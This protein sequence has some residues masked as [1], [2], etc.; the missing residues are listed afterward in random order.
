MKTAREILTQ[1]NTRSTLNTEQVLDAMEKYAQQFKYDY[2]QN[3]KCESTT[4]STW[5]CNQCGLPITK[6]EIT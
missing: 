5:C 6:K 3:C 2:S 4:G 1:I